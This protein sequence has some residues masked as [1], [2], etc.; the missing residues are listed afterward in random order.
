MI[1]SLR[2]PRVPSID[3]WIDEALGDSRTEEHSAV[4]LIAREE[5][6]G[7]EPLMPSSLRPQAH[8]AHPDVECWQPNAETLWPE[9][10]APRDGAETLRPTGEEQT[11]EALPATLAWHSDRVEELSALLEGDELALLRFGRTG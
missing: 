1:P 9:G 2:Q 7:S 3:H 5:Y 8:I 6:D 10:Q 4:N 11:R